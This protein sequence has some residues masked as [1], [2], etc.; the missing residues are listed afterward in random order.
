EIVD[1]AWPPE[2]RMAAEHQNWK[3]TISRL[4]ADRRRL[5]LHLSQWQRAC[6]VYFHPSFICIVLYRVSRHFFQTG[7]PLLARLIGQF[8]QVLTGADISPASDI[9]EGFVVLTPPGAAI[10]GKAGRNLTV[11][12]CAGI[13]GEIG[14]RED[15][16]GGPGHPVLGDDVILE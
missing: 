9:G 7:H 6:G 16:G 14:R 13:G 2:T 12:P 11:M 1:A 15:V 5:L 4:K 10:Y 8:N 3:M